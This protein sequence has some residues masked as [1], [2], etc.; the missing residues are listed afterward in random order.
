MLSKVDYNS[1]EVMVSLLFCAQ[2][3]SFFLSHQFAGKDKMI[4]QM[5]YVAP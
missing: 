5:K 3:S 4:G 1:K 2:L